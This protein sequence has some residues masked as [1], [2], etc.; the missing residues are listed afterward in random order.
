[1]NKNQ[2]N[3]LLIDDNEQDYNSTRDLL[4][5]LKGWE[6]NLEWVS[7]Y[8][9]ALSKLEH[10][11]YDIC[12]LDCCI[13]DDNGLDFLQQATHNGNRPSLILLAES[14]E[15]NIAQEAMNAGAVDYLVKGQMDAAL[16]ER[17]LRYAVKHKDLADS[18]ETKVKERTT[19]LTQ[20]NEQLEQE[21]AHYKQREETLKKEEQQYRMFF[22]IDIYGVEVL[23]KEGN[24]VDCN[25]RYEH[26]LGYS[27]DEIIGQHVT[28]FTTDHSTK[29]FQKMLQEIQK[30][31]YSEGERELVH[32]DGSTLLVWSRSR[33]LHDASGGFSGIV[34][35]KRDITE[36]MKAVKQIS[37]L[38]RALEQSPVALMITDAD[39]I[40]EYTNFEFTELTGYTYEEI[41]GMNMHEMPR[42][43]ESPMSYQAFEDAVS[44]AEEWEGE[45]HNVR[46]DGETYWTLATVAPMFDA[47]GKVTHFIIIQEDITARKE[48][49]S[50]ALRAQRR[51]GDLM[52]EQIDDLTSANEEFQR[53]I[54]E[55]IRMHEALEQSRARLEAQYKGIP[56][57]TYTWEI[58]DDDFVLVNYNHAA[59]E[60]SQIAQFKGKKAGEIFKDRPQVLGDFLRCSIEKTI[61]KREAPYTMI[62][63][64]ETRHFVTTYNFVAPN[65]IIVHIQDI[66]EYKH[67]E[68]E[69]ASFRDQ[70]DA[71]AT[72]DNGSSQAKEALA[73]EIAKREEV[74]QAL[75]NAEE[76]LKEVASNID[77]RLREQ[78]RSIPVPTY[79]WQKIG[80]EFIL[81]DFNDAAAESMGRI[82]DFF[83]KPASEIFE[84]R[85]QILADF[86]ECY[87]EQKTLIREAPYK[88]ITTGETKYFVTTYN[89][90]APNLVVDHIQ[91]IT[92]QKRMEEE[93]AQCREQ[94]ADKAPPPFQDAEINE[95]TAGLRKKIEELQEELA[96]HERAEETLRQNRARLKAQ[97]N[98]IPIPT[99]S[100]QRVGDD[101]ILIDHNSAAENATHGHIVE[102]M[103]K[104]AGEVFKDRPEV[105]ADFSR[106]FTE[107]TTLRRESHYQL[108]TADETKHF[109]TTYSFVPPNLVVVYSEDITEHKQIEKLLRRGEE[110]VDLVCRL[111]P[112]ATLTYVNDAYCWYFNQDRETLI[113]QTIPFVHQDD[114]QQVK[115]HLATLRMENPVGTVEY[116]IIKPNGDIRWQQWVNHSVFDD[117]GR[118][119]E[120]QA[121]GRDITR[122]KEQT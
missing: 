80:G 22:N 33:A 20:V 120:I 105:L 73:R 62:T 55:R 87:N 4:A 56:V 99:Y 57:P 8:E 18:L 37:T 102:F 90:V 1:M 100:W 84:N 24:I 25:P 112:Q 114:Q 5:E 29:A 15:D 97:Y 59:E 81:V 9:A 44:A 63:T 43:D 68:E 34:T 88:M 54:D 89:Y 21:V 35:F 11:R 32:K 6:V 60:S 79:T 40:I 71:T 108:L 45:L 66:T 95:G 77:E 51:I 104:S 72:E 113:G 49:E 121:R 42:G 13:D 78:Y 119:V 93:L 111:S 58:Q 103:G 115:M 122:R 10:D 2:L 82:V 116:R 85:P 47:K 83:G 19:K 92:A 7:S 74:E 106:C 70:L 27:R 107:K 64:G 75:R 26:L 69:W 31:G 17:S 50:E 67:L 48:E 16:L 110:Q 3:T 101:F 91:D 38:A 52:T 109:V 28:T 86:A 53:E 76:R 41:I 96:K 46:K 118:L 117:Q 14:D 98:G 30:K 65:L 94:L 12:L 36:R 61:V 39:G 23:D